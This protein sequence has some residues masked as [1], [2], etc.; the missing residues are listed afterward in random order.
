LNVDFTVVI[1]L[2]NKESRIVDCLISVLNQGSVPNEVII[3][4][5]GS[6][7][8]SATLVKEFISSHPLIRFKIV[9]QPNRGVAAARNLGVSLSNN[10]FVCFLDADDE[11][12]KDFLSSM[13]KL[14]TEFPAA[15]LYCAGHLV[16]KD[17]R[18]RPPRLNATVP[19]GYI[20]DFFYAS[21]NAEIANSSK[22]CIRK[23]AICNIGGFP[24]GVV[25]GED[26]YVWSRLALKGKVAYDPSALA[27]IFYHNDPARQRRAR[28][29]PYIIDYFAGVE[30][31]K[32]LP[33]S[34][35]RYI[36]YIALSHLLDSL[37]NH[38]YYGWVVRWKSL[39]R[40]SP[41]SGLLLMPT[42]IIPGGVV[43]LLRKRAARRSVVR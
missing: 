41:L 32:Q 12:T 6:S 26:L 1:P 15:D 31:K 40:F 43:N 21:V 9:Q 28:S 42:M 36:R 34:L 2:F 3:V 4:D 24:E 14:I 22:V 20:T 23:S 30:N 13:R 11:W 5:D 10:E 39:F 19:R 27:K 17:G 18:I 35:Y 8:R 33:K 25:C 37:S 7:D 38:D 16:V 29:V